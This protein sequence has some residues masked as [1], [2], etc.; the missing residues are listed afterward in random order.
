[1]ENAKNVAADV[2]GAVET[3]VAAKKARK[4]RAAVQVSSIHFI[5]AYLSVAKTGGTNAEVARV[6]NEKYPGCDV[7][8]AKVSIRASQITGPACPQVLVDAIRKAGKLDWIE[9]VKLEDGSTYECVKLPVRTANSTN[10]VRV[11]SE[12]DIAALADFGDIDFGERLGS[13]TL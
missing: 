7:D 8:A 4:A 3:L 2:S 12:D 1:M 5:L 10:R 11:V 6:L 9:T 13:A